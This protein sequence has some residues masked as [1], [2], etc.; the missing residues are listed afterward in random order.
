MAQDGIL[1]KIFFNIL[2]VQKFERETIPII[3]GFPL[4]FHCFEIIPLIINQMTENLLTILNTKNKK[5]HIHF[6][7]LC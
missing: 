5:F 2:L 3:C 1:F 4:V 6:K 7:Q